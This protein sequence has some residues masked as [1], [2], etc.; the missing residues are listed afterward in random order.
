MALSAGT[1]LGPYEILSPLGAGGMGEVYRAHDT[2]LDRT[3]AIKVLPEAL[4]ADSQFR[5]RFDREAKAIS[6]LNHPHICTLYDIGSQDGTDFLVM[7]YLDGETLADKL[8][9]GPLPLDQALRYA[10]EIADALD[11]AHRTGIT[12]RDLKPGNIM[13]T[14]TGTK[15]LDFGLA[16]T[17]VPA[18]AGTSLSML[19]TTPPSLTARGTILGTFQYMAPEQIEGEQ[20]DARTD[21]F[22]FG[23][24]LYE[25]LTGKKAFAGK[26]QASLFGAILKE[27]PPPISTIDPLT[28]PLL[29]RV[30]KKC[31]AKDPD[32]R[33]QTAHDLLD[34]LR[35]VA[36]GA[37][38]LVAAAPA[39]GRATRERVAWTVVA[40]LAAAAI[41]LGI[42]YLRSA[43][44]D[45]HPIRFSVSLPENA[46]LNT[47][48]VPVVSPDGRRVAFI[49]NRVGG[50][51]LLWV[52]AL[53][54]LE[55]QPLPGTENALVPF[56]SPDSRTLGFFAAGKLKTIDAAGGS[57]QS[58]CDAIDG[59]GGTWNRD[60][61]IVFA[62]D[63][64]GG[65]FRVPAAGGQP[66]PV[67]TPDVTR[68][69][70]AHRLPAFL[71]DAR[72]FLFS[73]SPSNTIWLGSLDSK[74]TTRLLNADSQAQYAAPGYLLF[75]RQGTLFAQPFDA[76]R[77]TLTGDAVPIAEQL[78]FG[79]SVNYLGFSVS[80]S[81]VLA[82][83]SG[84]PNTRT[85]LTWFDRTGKTL[86]PTAQPGLYRNPTLS[87]D[88]TRVAVEATDP[89]SRTE[90]I[91]VVELARGVTSRFTF[92]P[93]NDIYPVWSPDGSRLMFGSDRESD[94]F[95]LYQKRAD[96]VGSEQ[97]VLK[98]PAEMV[99]N[100]WSPDGRAL[101]YRTRPG[102]S[103]G[104]FNLGILP[105]VGDRK[106]HLFEASRAVQVTGQVSPDGRWL[107][108]HSLESGRYEVYVQSFPAPGAGKWQISK[109]G[110]ANS[111]WRGDGREL[112]YY[113]L[114]GRLMAVLIAGSTG[115]EV[116]AA[117][118]LFEARMLNGPV[119]LGGF[120][121]QYDVTRDGQRF[122]LTVPLE[123][124]AA[125]PITVV[126]NWTAALE[127]K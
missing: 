12:H 58:L 85:Q 35:W 74:E 77:A 63:A 55:A 81:G 96:G 87:P 118:P 126:L 61:V 106:P 120:K 14:R 121:Q 19:P 70:T 56:W 108:Y 110:G 117:I 22:A 72:H 24:V 48:T 105:L 39:A 107:A 114:D 84:T 52:R 7:E 88:G 18:M 57:V 94:V 76:G 116:G 115:L 78:A 69:E 11:K 112:F 64:T 5:E 68:S 82:Y 83:R 119:P 67:T 46:R 8:A 75:G 86:G 50:E 25:M 34:G 98:S 53:D 47:N 124:T 44:S 73:A 51:A 13:L 109:D 41:A 10:I 40:V 32:N 27:E 28:P 1:R 38:D 93:G 103:S 16:K 42:P 99:P 127:K 23:V 92:D 21:L 49:A 3:V 45:V 97:Q 80:D 43:S 54:A 111:R 26:T 20:A 100:S 36:E 60:G 102:G 89:Q 17:D 4:A 104:V 29:D 79:A 33:W 59:R 6:Q 62:P 101:V 91:W 66:T 90:D 30:V 95:N 15:L 125:S 123:E 9:K 113:A 122:L 31:L 71:P 37:H 65:L 2:R